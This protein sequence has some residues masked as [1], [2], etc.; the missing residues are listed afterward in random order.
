MIEGNT[1]LPTGVDAICFTNSTPTQQLHMERQLYLAVLVANC[2]ILES[3]HKTCVSIRLSAASECDYI[4]HFTTFALKCC[5]HNVLHQ[6]ISY[7]KTTMYHETTWILL[8]PCTC[9][10]HKY[11]CPLSHLEVVE[12]F[13]SLYYICG[14]MINRKLDCEDLHHALATITHTHTLVPPLSPRSC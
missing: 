8:L 10:N 13:K 11:T 5:G 3:S 1:P 6:S 4:C 14:H 7:R 2:G 12:T 9:H